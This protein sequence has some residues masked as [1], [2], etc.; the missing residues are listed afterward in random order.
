MIQSFLCIDLHGWRKCRKIVWNNRGPHFPVG[1]AGGRATQGAV[2][3]NNA[4]SNCRGDTKSTKKYHTRVR[5][6]RAFRRSTVAVPELL[7][8]N[9]YRTLQM[10]RSQRRIIS[11]IVKII[12]RGD[13]QIFRFQYIGIGGQ[14]LL[15]AVG[16][17]F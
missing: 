9:A 11:G 15:V 8:K 17:D 6:F 10:Q 13:A 4:G 7:Y 1:Y 5:V 2:A 12:M 16:G 14:T 3:E